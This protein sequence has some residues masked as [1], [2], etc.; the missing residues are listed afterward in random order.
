MAQ[1]IPLT[2]LANQRGYTPDKSVYDPT[3]ATVYGSDGSKVGTVHSALVDPD[4]GKMRYLVVNTGGWFS[5]KEVIVPVG[6]SRIEDDGVYFDSLTKAQVG[7]MQEYRQGMD[8]TPDHQSHT[9]SVLSGK[10]V[11]TPPVAA[12][13]TTT[14]AAA[15]Y[16]YDDTSRKD[17]FK[18]PGK[19]QL[20][21]ERLT[22]NKTREQAGAVE[23]GKRVVT[24]E[25]NVNVSLSHDEVVIER[26]PVTDGRPVDGNVKLGA[27]SEAIRVDLEA[28]KAAVGKQAFVAEEVDVSKRQVG[29]TKTFTE[30]VGREELDVKRTGDVEVRNEGASSTSSTTSNKSTDK[31]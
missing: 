11:S 29:E 17:M 24:R 6:M 1:L 5:N 28:E 2:E 22:V 10:A 27:S 15:T 21:E 16:D 4:S 25:E 7:Q 31:R 3:G 20:L 9:E 13:S 23:V 14:A 12:A 18:T 26:H 30:T 8:V 19:L